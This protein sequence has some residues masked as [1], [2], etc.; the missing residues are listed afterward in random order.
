MIQKQLPLKNNIYRVLQGLQYIM[1]QSGL[2]TKPAKPVSTSGKKRCRK[3]GTNRMSVD[4]KRSTPQAKYPGAN[5]GFSRGARKFR[6]KYFLHFK[7]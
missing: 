3:A 2:S 5:H 6:G 1:L 4:G 7:I